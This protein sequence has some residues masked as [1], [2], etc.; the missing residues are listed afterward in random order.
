VSRESLEI[1][2]KSL[3]L[4]RVLTGPVFCLLAAGLMF[5]R[6]RA[7]SSTTQA[8]HTDAGGG[9][10]RIAFEVASIKQNKSGEPAYRATSNF[11][12]GLGESYAPNGGLF[13]A[14]NHSVSSYIGFAYRLSPYET[15]AMANALPKWAKDERFDIQAR[16]G[17]SATKDQMRLMMRSLLADRFKLVAHSETHEGPIFAMVLLKPDET[18]PRLHLHSDD[19]GPCGPFTTSPSARLPGGIPSSCDIFLT[20]LDAGHAQ[21]S[22]RN[23]SME[24]IANS[25]GPFDRPVMDRTGLS[26]LY[27]FTIE[28]TPETTQP[29]ETGTSYLEAMKEQ[30][31]LKLESTT[32]PIRDLI[33][34]QIEEP[35]P[36]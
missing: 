15:K 2:R 27:D 31:G 19:L 12:L 8:S 7:Q 18:G 21:M 26:G 13:T 1:G 28:W 30:L 10:G 14:T 6:L 17:A 20:L 36:N 34:D 33:V 35:S 25:L 22:A 5:P 24:M 32:G 11:P 23:V 16:A 3:R 4:K 9:V 29:M